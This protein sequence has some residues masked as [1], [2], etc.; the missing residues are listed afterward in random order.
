MASNNAGSIF[1]D[2]KV[3]DK[4][5]DQI[6]KSIENVQRLGDAID[7]VKKASLL[8][9]VG[10]GAEMIRK[11]LFD[12]N[13]VRR[14]LEASVQRGMQLKLDTSQAERQ[15]ERLKQKEQE[16][17]E[18]SSRLATTPL[19]QVR[20]ATSGS[21]IRN[22]M[23][24]ARDTLQGQN[25]GVTRAAAQA[26]REQAQAQ[27]Q[28]N[29]AKREEEALNNRIMRQMDGITTRSN[30]LSGIFGELSNQIGMAFSV[31]SM[32]QFAKS[33]IT[34]GGQFEQQHVALKSI[35]GDVQQANDTF[36]NLKTL[37]VV[38]PFSFRE[39]TSYTK[40]LS[41]FSIPYNELFDTTKRLADISAGLGVDMSRIILAYGQVRS[42]SVLRGQE[43]RQFTEAGIPMVEA[44]AQKLTEARGELVSTADVF[45]LISQRAVSFNMVKEILEDM[46][47]EGGRF[48]NMQFVLSDTLYG[49]WSNL[50][51]AWE[52]ML[53]DIAKG[54]SASGKFL[55]GMVA[56][57][58]ELIKLMNEF[59]AG[60]ATMIG[61]FMLRGVGRW[62][63][64]KF[65]TGYGNMLKAAAAVNMQDY[66]TA[67]GK[68][69]TERTAREAELIKNQGK[70]SANDYKRLAVLNS[71]NT[72]L[73]QQMRQHGLINTRVVAQ[74]HMQGVITREQAKQILNNRSLLS[75]MQGLS[76]FSKTL[77]ANLKSLGWI[78]AISAA[79]QGIATVAGKLGDAERLA[80][81]AAEGWTQRYQEL[82]DVLNGISES[83]PTSEAGYANAISSIMSALQDSRSDY[84]DIKKEAEGIS[85]LGDRYEY[86]RGKL[87]T[88]TEGYKEMSENKKYYEDLIS[89]T[90]ITGDAN[91]FESALQRLGFGNIN[92]TAETTEELAQ[93]F[94]AVQ[95][96]LGRYASGIQSMIDKTFGEEQQKK[97][98]MFGKTLQEQLDILSRNDTAR[99]TLITGLSSNGDDE[100]LSIVQRYF[101][102]SKSIE[103]NR[104]KLEK[105]AK[106]AAESI[107]KDMGLD[108][109]DMSRATEKDKETIRM[110]FDGF[111][112][113]LE[114]AGENARRIARGIMYDLGNITLPQVG[115]GG[116]IPSNMYKYVRSRLGQVFFPD[117]ASGVNQNILQMT[118]DDTGVQKSWSSLMSTIK[119]AYDESKKDLDIIRGQRGDTSTIS[120]DE[121]AAQRRFDM[122]QEA[123]NALYVDTNKSGGN[124]TGGNGTDKWLQNMSKQITLLERYMNV[125]RELADVYGEAEAKRRMAESGDYSSL[126]ALGITD[127]SATEANYNK[128]IALLNSRQ[129]GSE[130]RKRKLEE[131]QL[132]KTNAARKE[133]I[134]QIKE[135]NDAL[136]D[137]LDLLNSQ[138]DVYKQWIDMTGNKNVAGAVAFGDMPTYGNYRDQL[139]AML[140]E[141]LG[142]SMSADQALAMYRDPSRRGEITKMFGEGSNSASGVPV[143]LER[144]DQAETAYFNSM[145][146]NMLKLYEDSK[147]LEQKLKDIDLETAKMTTF[148]NGLNISDEEKKGIIDMQ[149]E[150]ADRRKADLEFDEFRR[151]PE[152]GMA[153]GELDRLTST[154]LESLIEKLNQKSA[155]AGLGAQDMK[156]LQDAITK[157]EDEL[158]NRNPFS[159]IAGSITQANRLGDLSRTIGSTIGSRK[160]GVYTDTTFTPNAAGAKR[161]GLQQGRQYT[162]DQVEGEERGAWADLP[163]GL[164]GLA[165]GFA[166]AQKALQPVIDLFDTL[167][168]EDLSNLFQT[169]SNA[170]GAAASASSGLSA[171]G[172]GSAGPYGA[173][174]AAGLSVT[175]SL[176]A[177]HDK[178][179]QKQIDASKRAQEAFENMS[180]T[181]EQLLEYNMGGVYNYSAD[182]T[183][184][185]QLRKKVG[186]EGVFASFLNNLF[187]GNY[188]GS[189]LYQAVEKAEASDWDYFSTQYALLIAQR[190][191][192]EKQLELEKDKKDS[193]ADAIQ[194]YEQQLTDLN[195]EVQNFTQDMANELYGIDFKSWA[196]SLTE[197]LVSAWASGANA[198]KAYKDAVGDILK[199]VVVSAISQKYIEQM[200]EPIVEDFLEQFEADNGKMTDRS[201]EILNDLY[202]IGEDATEAVNA[203]MDGLEQV[204][205][206]HGATLKDNSSGSST[207]SGIQSVTEET[208]DLLASY[209]NA[210][211]AYSAENMNSLKLINVSLTDY[212]PT[213]Q[214]TLSN[215][216]SVQRS[217]EN[218]TRAT[219][220][221]NAEILT[222]IRSIM[223]P[224]S[225]GKGVRV[226]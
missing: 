34:I 54:E 69:A 31:Y 225:D 102:M 61:G 74:M 107:I 188:K 41:A 64:N 220:E 24:D 101:Q 131:V 163:D 140:N 67:L 79:I 83:A 148:V 190:D 13:R 166:N 157:L 204:A 30:R 156:T 208:A 8:K 7:D 213:M 198:A 2:L 56:G 146:D 177:M 195:L 19:G 182:E 96:K 189:E 82:R 164:Q 137:Q 10:G 185:N 211:R 65:G 180:N 16:L 138:W 52:I 118:Q 196:N 221:S 170:L 123:Y 50:Q 72:A 173:A 120:A 76:N 192:A 59:G 114:N 130:E 25:A 141:R 206:S 44:L 4:L 209:I 226:V 28:V 155:T 62:A 187:G 57:L 167:G 32:E 152:W 100:E 80:S 181:I 75:G 194:D 92:D 37:A 124:G 171:L 119:T 115:D 23:R 113:A 21:G 86:L 215:Q 191:E 12:V 87:Q 89:D 144:L 145:A 20:V 159:A 214:S 135:Q 134:D 85:D 9:D 27:T 40:Q 84:A 136:R 78:A 110:R 77:V 222:A 73:L 201:W 111:I 14:Q 97:L 55:K 109:N 108:P 106:Q 112:G 161:Y 36:A 174:I 71:Q 47:N 116:F 49:K 199:D 169:G 126:A 11:A 122:W 48:F 3:N 139:R 128:M 29:R 1:F 68:N 158:I 81:G 168:N 104:E 58:T 98:G 95:T 66:Q 94:K 200:M 147:L 22:M 39:L 5:S 218:N 93:N 186:L 90:S 43:L 88:T 70:L 197:T 17:I 103:L 153:M 202:S 105:Q 205:N 162:K 160:Y 184:R 35:L 132:S 45:K 172:L 125:Y 165:E 178:S 175:S 6:A 150:A 142:G 53:S 216:L 193:D 18:L 99:R 219:A 176:F 42:A 212:L 179:L 117:D 149:G 127:P 210:I 63:N 60:V 33:V 151:S 224:T 183:T 143:L 154:T 203:A 121:E 38:S 129:N 15:I 207:S 46:T 217:I 26:T 91:I 223:R 133:A 51:D